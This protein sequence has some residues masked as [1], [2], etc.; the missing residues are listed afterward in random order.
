MDL[1]EKKAA[2]LAAQYR[3]TEPEFARWAKGYGI[4]RHSDFTQVR[5]HELEKRSVAEGLQ[6]DGVPFYDVLRALDRVASAGMWLVVHQ[7]Y[8]RAVYLDGRPLSPNDFKERP[9]GHTGGS[10]NMVPA[11]AGY[12][13]ANVLNGFTRSWLM[14]QGHCVAAIDSLNLLVRNMAEAHARRYSLTDEGL[15]FDTH[16]TS[17]PI[18]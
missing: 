1:D 16:E 15:T 5:I 13:A 12:L 10:L 9:E 8:A 4:I 18:V 3:E 14:E 7:T 17:T 11:Y 6:G 2:E